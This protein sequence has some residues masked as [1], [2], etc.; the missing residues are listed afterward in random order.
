MVTMGTLS[1]TLQC[2]IGSDITEGPACRLTHTGTQW[3]NSCLKSNQTTSEE[4]LFPNP[5]VCQKGGELLKFSPGQQAL[6][7]T[8]LYCPYHHNVVGVA[9]SY[10]S[11]SARA[12]PGAIGPWPTSVYA[13]PQD[14]P[15]YPS[16]S[17]PSTL[18]SETPWPARH[19]A[20]LPRRPQ[21]NMFLTLLGSS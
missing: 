19:T 6:V 5:S 11:Q 14:E 8:I 9:Y 15:V 18:C 12:T 17:N 21:W 4:N 16:Y 10:S 3:K 20:I 13:F 2:T 7:N 1:P